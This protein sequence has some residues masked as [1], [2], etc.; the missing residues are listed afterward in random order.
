MKADVLVLALDTALAAC[1]AAVV[2]GEDDR[3]VA[4]AGHAMERG[5]AEALMP[6]VADV[7]A[8][9]GGLAA[10]G[11]LAVT[12]GPGSF[13]GIRVGL[14][15]ARALALATKM[16]VVG[17]STLVALA[18]PLL[19]ADDGV[20]V[21][22]AVDARH[23]RVFFQMFGRGARSLVP[24]RLLAVA[25]AARALGGGP[26]RVIGSGA[27][28][29][30]RAADRDGI[31][32]IAAPGVDAV[33]LARLGAAAPEPAGLPRPLYLRPADA[34]PQDGAAVPRR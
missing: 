5:H 34:R 9:A 7:V 21:A 22:A 25:D 15:A 3:V 23:G 26:V 24:A 1:S 30:A 29:L 16:P 4:A 28:P 13:T 27:D 6:M 32:V 2:D 20:P 14:A 19:A 18:A 8:A 11:R 33:W 31:E 10:I 12:T 17:L